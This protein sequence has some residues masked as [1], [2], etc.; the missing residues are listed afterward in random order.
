ML[1][2]LPPGDP[3][4]IVPL[5]LADSAFTH[6]ITRAALGNWRRR[7]PGA[8]ESRRVTVLPPLDEDLLAE[9]SVRHLRRTLTDL[10]EGGG[11]DT[12]LVLAAHGT[13]LAPPRPMETGREAT[14][15]IARRIGAMLEDQ[16]GLII[17]G[18]LNHVY[19][20]RWTEPPVE[21]ALLRV[22][23]AGFRKV[24][25]YPFGFVADNAESELEGRIA[26]RG[27]PELTAI[28]LP[29]LNDSPLY[30]DALARQIASGAGLRATAH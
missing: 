11:S 22:S 24:V 13:L 5:Y 12:A 28:H 7:R 26:L 3:V 17:H 4:S 8:P 9:I 27:R 15:R 23:E 10:G 20:G 18:W 6:E 14:E 30:L 2:R 16:F 1:D 19:G 29:C 25:Y 21:A